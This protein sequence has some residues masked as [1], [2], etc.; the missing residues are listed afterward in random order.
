MKEYKGRNNFILRTTS[1]LCQNVFEKCIEKNNVL[2]AKA[3]SK[4]YTLDCGCVCFRTFPH[5][6]A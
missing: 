2:I 4:N 5:S 3:I 6:Y 1:F